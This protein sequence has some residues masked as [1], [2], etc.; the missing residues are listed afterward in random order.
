MDM[1]VKR[2]LGESV[3]KEF[4]EA[5]FRKQ[6]KRIGLANYLVHCVKHP[7]KSLGSSIK[8]SWPG[9]SYVALDHVGRGDFNE[10]AYVNLRGEWIG[11]QCV[12]G[13]E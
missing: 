9:I 2:T 12:F 10:R 11:N 7:L 6:A 8:R 5:S 4:P 1:L 13:C 3:A